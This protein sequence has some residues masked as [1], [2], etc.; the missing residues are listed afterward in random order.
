MLDHDVDISAFTKCDPLENLCDKE[1]FMAVVL[2]CLEHKDYD[3]LLK[4]TEVHLSALH[5]KAIMQ[6]HKDDLVDK[7]TINRELLLES[8]E[9]LIRMGL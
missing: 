9:K 7:P 6:G 4:A 1:K 8:Y 3:F 5:K 2:E